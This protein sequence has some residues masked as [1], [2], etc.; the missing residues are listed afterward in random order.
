MKNFKALFVL[1]LLTVT[2]AVGQVFNKKPEVEE[3]P[4]MRELVRQ[5]KKEAKQK[6]EPYRYDASKITYFLYKPYEQSKEIEVFFFNNAEYKLSFNSKAV[7]DPITIKVYDRAKNQ[8]NRIL[9]YSKENVAKSEFGVTSKDLNKKLKEKVIARK[10][11][12][13]EDGLSEEEKAAFT[14]KIHLKKVYIDYIIPSKPRE[15]KQNPETG[16]METIRTKGAMVVA[17][18]YSNI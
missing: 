3:K 7:K 11:A 10:D 17:M 16:E 18:G 4:D 12:Q 5:Y 2:I 15:K 14:S 6:L 9:L 1:L 8:Q 13:S